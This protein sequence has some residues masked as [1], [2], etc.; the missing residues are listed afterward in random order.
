MSYRLPKFMMY[1]SERSP[2]SPYRTQLFGT[3]T[4]LTITYFEVKA[5]NV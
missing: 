2:E 4:Q 1:S 3:G 5:F